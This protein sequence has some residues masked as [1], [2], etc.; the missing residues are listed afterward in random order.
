[1]NTRAFRIAV[2]IKTLCH[3]N[4]DAAVYND[5]QSIRS[6]GYHRTIDHDQYGYPLWEYGQEEER[7][8]WKLPFALM[9]PIS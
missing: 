6:A 3:G 8:F 9:L 5:E 4:V 2:A 7:P 1:M